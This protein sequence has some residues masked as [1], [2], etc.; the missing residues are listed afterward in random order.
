M[1]VILWQSC[2][3]QVIRQKIYMEEM[4]GSFRLILNVIMLRENQSHSRIIIEKITKTIFP[5]KPRLPSLEGER[6]IKNV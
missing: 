4:I 3:E 2:K 5:P 6:V 1:R